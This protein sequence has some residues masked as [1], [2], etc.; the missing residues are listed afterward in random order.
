MIVIPINMDKSARVRDA[1]EALYRE[2]L[3]AGLEVVLDDR[4]QRPGFKFADA[5]LIGYPHR[6]VIAEKGL[7]KD[8]IEYKSRR[9]PESMQIPRIGVVAHIRGG[10]RK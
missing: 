4:P 9:A 2:L 8:E 7:D 10:A 5:D 3:D 1:A 6:L